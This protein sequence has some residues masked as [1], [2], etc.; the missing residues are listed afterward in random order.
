VKRGRLALAAAGTAALVALASVDREPPARPQAAPE[1]AAP[2][3]PAGMPEPP[4]RAQG[5]GLEP[6]DVEAAFRRRP[7]PETGD[8]FGARTWTPPPKPAA[9]PPPRPAPPPLPFAFLGR[10]KDEGDEGEPTVVLRRGN[11]VG[12]AREHQA[13]DAS[14]RLEAIGPRGLVFTY[15]PLKEQ[16]ILPLDK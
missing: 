7:L 14:Y 2:E 6:A 1:S 13:I 4:G 12:L 9:G 8:A 3:G 5:P 15:L 16:Q 10:L 11:M